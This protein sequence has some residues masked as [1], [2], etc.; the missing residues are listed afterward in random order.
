MKV[1]C[2]KQYSGN[3][4][5]GGHLVFEAICEAMSEIFA[6]EVKEFSMYDEPSLKKRFQYLTSVRRCARDALKNGDHIYGLGKAGTIDYI[7]P[8]INR[9]GFLGSLETLK[10]WLTL[11]YLSAFSDYRKVCMFGSNY[12]KKIERKS[13]CKGPVIYPP[14]LENIEFIDGER[15]NIILA[16][17][18]IS[19][20]KNIE[21][22]GRLSDVVDAKF[23]VIGFVTKSNR[24][25]LAK[26]KKEFP[27]LTILTDVPA[28][29]KLKWLRKAKILLHAA[30]NEPYGMTKI[31]GM[32]A[33]CVPLVHNSGGSPENIPDGY[34]F[35]NIDEAK[36]KIVEILREYNLD[37]AIKMSDFVKNMNLE[38]FKRQIKLYLKEVLDKNTENSKISL[39]GI[40]RY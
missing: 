8:I 37:I 6:V 35:D 3:G 28:E 16:I 10:E 12:I 36:T 39:E 14:L 40:G 9:K 26:L 24:K 30:I 11:N 31:E 15:E 25:Y 13:S 38:S 29:E 23:V 33:G 21:F 5:T 32:A 27:K 2:F 4:K 7:V 20:E 22:V 19:R 34:T 17:S 18:R 1:I